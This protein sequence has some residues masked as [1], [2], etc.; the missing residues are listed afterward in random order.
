MTAVDGIAIVYALEAIEDGD[1]AHAVDLLLA[2]LE[3]GPITDP[4]ASTACP[5][6]GCLYSG[7]PGEVHKHLAITHGRLPA[8]TAPR[9]LVRTAPRSRA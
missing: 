8:R 4:K 3:S 1:I 7:W 9:R 6:P 5:V 2:A